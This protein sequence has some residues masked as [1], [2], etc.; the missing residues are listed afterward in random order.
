[1]DQILQ[2]WD[3]HNWG[4]QATVQ[5]IIY[6]MIASMYKYIFTT[7]IH[8]SLCIYSLKLCLCMFQYFLNFA[9]TLPFFFP[10]VTNIHKKFILVTLLKVAFLVVF[11]PFLCIMTFLFFYF[12]RTVQYFHIGI[13]TDVLGITTMITSVQRSFCSM[14]LSVGSHVGLF[15]TNLR[16]FYF[17]FWELNCAKPFEDIL[18]SYS[19]LCSDSHQTKKICFPFLGSFRTV[20]GMFLFSWEVLNFFQ[21]FCFGN[22]YYDK[23]I[24][25][26]YYL[27]WTILSFFWFTLR[28]S[29]YFK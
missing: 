27:R 22:F 24:R 7:C 23:K 26:S 11:C 6:M 1:M 2:M 4:V 13:C 12:L 3:G 25:A 5:T 15:S 10:V 28:H 16:H 9:S 18:C 19:S 20:L 21:A 14:S 29:S 8:I 17:L